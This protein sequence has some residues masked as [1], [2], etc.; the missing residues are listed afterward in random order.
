M[1]KKGWVKIRERLPRGYKWAGQWGKRKR[2]RKERAMGKMMMGIRKE[3][4]EEG[5]KIETETEGL[6]V[7][8]VRRDGKIEDSGGIYRQG[9]AEKDAK[10]VRGVDRI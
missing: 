7:G 9:R 2:S 10:R 3:L 8:K 1:E 4:M 5:A 6:M